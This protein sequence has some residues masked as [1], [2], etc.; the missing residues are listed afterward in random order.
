[1]QVNEPFMFKRVHFN[2]CLLQN[3]HQESSVNKSFSC[4]KNLADRMIS[5]GAH[6]YGGSVGTITKMAE[7]FKKPNLPQSRSLVKLL[8]NKSDLDV[9]FT[10]G[11]EKHT[12]SPKIRKSNSYIVENDQYISRNFRN[13][14]TEYDVT[15]RDSRNNVENIY[16][17]ISGS[18]SEDRKSVTVVNDTY[19]FAENV[20][21]LMTNNEYAVPYKKTDHNKNSLLVENDTYTPFSNNEVNPYAVTIQDVEYASVDNIYENPDDL[22]VSSQIPSVPPPRTKKTDKKEHEQEKGGEPKSKSSIGQSIR[23]HANRMSKIW[24]KKNK[25][26]S[27]DSLSS[28]KEETN[29]TVLLEELQKILDNKKQEIQV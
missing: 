3:K 6:S 10:C 21:T 5:I 18:S 11:D 4:N 8:Q 17:R 12:K 1:M 16:E 19:E 2:Q 22:K 9:S 7:S 26:E 29:E 28:S 13:S 27:V 23:K 20:A 25:K 15:I 14:G 24:K